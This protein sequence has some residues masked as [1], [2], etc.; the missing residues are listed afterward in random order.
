MPVET[1]EA[2]P[3]LRPSACPPPLEPLGH[4]I[5]SRRDKVEPVGQEHARR[6]QAHHE[7][8]AVEARVVADNLDFK[9]H[10]QGQLDGN[11]RGHGPVAQQHEPVLQDQPHDAGGNL[12]RLGRH[13]V[14]VRADDEPGRT[15]V[16]QEADA[17][18][19]L[20][21]RPQPLLRPGQLNSGVASGRHLR[22]ANLPHAEDEGDDAEPR[23][24]SRCAKGEC[25]K[26]R[27]GELRVLPA[28]RCIHG[29]VAGEHLPPHQHLQAVATEHHCAP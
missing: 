4:E 20:D 24:L 19:R 13:A 23:P 8:E 9:E 28:V 12:S 26:Q 18:A 21:A 25:R 16:Q 15:V 5:H 10:L 29:Q 7:V 27:K 11:V 6:G 3:V 22:E 14:H 17:V 2:V 1:L